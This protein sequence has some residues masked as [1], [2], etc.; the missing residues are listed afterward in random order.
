MRVWDMRQ[1]NPAANIAL[2]DRIYAMDSKQ[3][4]VVL[5]TADKMIHIFDMTG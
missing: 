3:K 5:G 2:S 4:A 1:P